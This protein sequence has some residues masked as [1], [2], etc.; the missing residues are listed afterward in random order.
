M[1]RAPRSQSGRRAYRRGLDAEFAS[2]WLLRLKGYRILATRYRT[3]VGEIDIIARKSDQLA[4]IEVKAR[5]RIDDAGAAIDRRQW[6]RLYNAASCFLAGNPHLAGLTVRFD[7][8]L[9]PSTGWPVHIR[10][11][12][13]Q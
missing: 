12:W 4:I 3:P 2:R 8:I 1:I 7:A 13:R 5:D 9:V 11:A 10:D 6:G